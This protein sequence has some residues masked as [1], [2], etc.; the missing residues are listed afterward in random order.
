MEL[1]SGHRC[2]HRRCHH[3]EVLIAAKVNW[4][5]DTRST[6]RPVTCHVKVAP[7]QSMQI[8]TPLSLSPVSPIHSGDGLQS[9]VWSVTL[10]VH[11]VC[12]RSFSSY[13]NSFFV[14]SCR[15]TSD[16]QMHE[17]KT[18]GTCSVCAPVCQCAQ[19]T[20]L[21]NYQRS[22]VLYARELYRFN[23]IIAMRYC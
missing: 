17:S 13:F 22:V 2:R 5:I 23:E 19:S 4:K 12:I 20:S 1:M 3:I 14:F 18:A 21:I 16:A 8:S 7:S 11:C 9:P 10:R 6:C 15:R